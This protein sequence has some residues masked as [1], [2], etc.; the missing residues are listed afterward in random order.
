MPVSRRKAIALIGGGAVLAAN[1]SVATFWGTRTPHAALAPWDMA[2]GYNDP[3]LNAVSFGLLA[4]NPHNLQPWMIELVG[5][6]GLLL[7]HDTSKRLPETDPF[8]RQI[9][10]GMGCVLEQ[11]RIAASSMGYSVDMQP[12]PYGANGPVATLTFASEGNADPM[13]AGIMNR[14][15]CKEPFEDKPVPESLAE[16]LA[17]FADIYTDPAVVETV[18]KL[19]FDAWQ[20]EYETPRTLQESIDLMRMGKSEINASPDGLDIGGGFLE[21]AMALGMVS[22]E[23]LATPGTYSFE[24]GVRMYKT[25]LEATPAY[26]VLTS[27]TN[28]RADQLDAGARWL[29]LNL[30][31][32]QAGLAL[33]PV[34]Q[35]LQEYPEMHDHY[36]A[37]HEIFAGPG[38]TVQM[39]G[40]LGYGP[41]IPRTPRWALEHKLKH[42]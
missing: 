41:T 26:A 7:H 21:S 35:C 1:A 22:R 40:R 33:H 14:R 24:E 36:A 38:E 28:T 20:V 31:T 19:T 34:S 13:V 15:S 39:L 8:D 16:K 18:R 25:I 11:T 17:T 32:T 2:G 27:K 37:A 10:I 9:M 6:D 23:D 4:P 29:R 42:A 12:F 3:R 5:D 30:A